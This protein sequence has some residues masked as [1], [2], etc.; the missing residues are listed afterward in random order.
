[1]EQESIERLLDRKNVI[2]VVGVSRSPEK[3]GHQVYR[4]LKSAGYKVYPINPKAAEI[5]GDRCYLDLKALPEKPDL[6]CFVVPPKVTEEILRTCM[7]IGIR[8]VWM[9]PGAESEKAIELCHSNG[10]EVIYGTCIMLQHKAL[11]ERK[12]LATGE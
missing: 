7:E 10:I 11:E 12:G 1:M 5:L 8:R 3:Y 2:A 6:V 4:Y 9:Q